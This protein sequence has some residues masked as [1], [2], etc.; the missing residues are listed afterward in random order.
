MRCDGLLGG[1]TMGARTA[2]E[3]LPVLWSRPLAAWNLRFALFEV[4]AHLEF[5]LQRGRVIKRE[6]ETERWEVTGG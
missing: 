5:L 4:L 3:L 2:R 6:G 1:L